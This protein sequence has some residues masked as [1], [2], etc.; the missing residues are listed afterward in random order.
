MTKCTLENLAK[1]IESEAK[2]AAK[3]VR[4]A[5][6]RAVNETAFHAR[7]N[8]ISKYR[9]SFTVRSSG[10]P[11]S[12][13]VKKATVQ[14]LQAEVY[15]PHDWFYLHTVG[16]EKTAKGSHSMVIPSKDF[17]DLRLASGKVRKR[18]LPVELLKYANAHPKKTRGRVAWPKAFLKLKTKSGKPTIARRDKMNRKDMVWLYVENQKARVKKRWDFKEIVAHTAKFD[19]RYEYEKALKWQELH[20]K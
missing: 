10:L 2:K 18:N 8:L 15:F 20:K 11:Q 5:A 7:S 4:F 6:Q 16:G 17:P 14:N 3:R 13:K 9:V 19:L 1:T 12:V